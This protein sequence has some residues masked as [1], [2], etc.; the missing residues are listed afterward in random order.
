MFVIVVCLVAEIH[1]QKVWFTHWFLL[2]NVMAHVLHTELETAP[3]QVSNWL[4]NLEILLLI[5]E[6]VKIL[7]YC[8][9]RFWIAVHRGCSDSVDGLNG[10][11]GSVILNG[12]NYT[13]CQPLDTSG[14]LAN[15][16]LTIYMKYACNNKLFIDLKRIFFIISTKVSRVTI[17][18]KAS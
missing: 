16:N 11:N 2:Q 18:K 8:N 15:K 13:L 1:Q 14:L 12:I 9:K 6:P 5:K 3:T 7:S 4:N 10:K 17:T